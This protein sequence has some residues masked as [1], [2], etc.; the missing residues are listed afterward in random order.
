MEL[1]LCP[2]VAAN[3]GGL[4]GRKRNGMVQRKNIDS[5]LSS[6][7]L[8]DRFGRR[9]HTLAHLATFKLSRVSSKRPLTTAG[10]AASSLIITGLPKLYRANAVT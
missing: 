7:Q 1:L 5:G 3:W 6:F 10:N 4:S 8:D 9:H 2:K